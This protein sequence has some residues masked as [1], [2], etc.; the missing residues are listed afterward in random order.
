MAA[1]Q[2][3]IDT[4]ALGESLDGVP[5]WHNVPSWALLSTRDNSLPLEAQR[6]MAKRAGSS[7]I[8]VEASHA[9]PVSQPVAVAGLIMTGARAIGTIQK[10]ATPQQ[11]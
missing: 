7:V 8:E 10:V 5:T 6:F 9:A 2:R 3:P 11:H 4:A 1:A